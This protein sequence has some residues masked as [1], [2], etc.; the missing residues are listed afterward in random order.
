MI[1][2][3][4]KFENGIRVEEVDFDYDLHIFKVYSGDR[5]LGN[6]WPSI[7]EDMNECIAQLNDG[8]DPVTDSWEDGYGNPCTLDGWG[9]CRLGNQCTLDGWKAW[10][11]N[12]ENEKI[13]QAIDEWI[14]YGGFICSDYNRQTA[15]YEL[16]STIDSTTYCEF[17]QEN[18][19]EDT[20]E[21]QKE[22]CKNALISV[23][24]PDEVIEELM[25]NW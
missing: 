2:K 1:Y 12:R 9:E 4:W 22:F 14:E 10:K 18:K 19:L 7:I 25:E 15:C 17:L 21:N 16:F 5:Y 13:I 6:V 8:S 23:D 3:E 11:K 24:V 20:E